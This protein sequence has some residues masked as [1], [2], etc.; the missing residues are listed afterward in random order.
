MQREDLFGF[1][2]VRNI[3]SM[4]EGQVCGRATRWTVPLGY[5]IPRWQQ[6]QRQRGVHRVSKN[7]QP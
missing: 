3:N 5:S 1:M 2:T 7:A 4:K 6:Q